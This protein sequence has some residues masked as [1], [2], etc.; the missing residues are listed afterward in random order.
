MKILVIFFILVALTGCSATSYQPLKGG[1]GYSE[2]QLSEDIYKVNFKGNGYTSAE[3]ASDFSLLRCAELSIAN[4]FKYF[5]S[6]SEQTQMDSQSFYVPATT[7]NYSSGY[8]YTSGG[9]GGVSQSP[10]SSYTIKMTNTEND[11]T[12]DAQLIIE[13]IELKYAQNKSFQKSR[14]APNIKSG[15]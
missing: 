11:F 1:G 3:Q 10:L 13:S 14:S 5:Y 6:L 15:N 7:Y 2:T 8:S 12:Y 9:F 4:N